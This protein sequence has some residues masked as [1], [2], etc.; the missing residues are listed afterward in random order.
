MG[1]VKLSKVWQLP[2]KVGLGLLILGV[3]GITPLASGHT[4]E[5]GHRSRAS[6][7]ARSGGQAPPVYQRPVIDRG[8]LLQATQQMLH[9]VSEL[10]GLPVIHSVKAALQSREEIQRSLIKDLDERTTADE[11]EA[12]TKL[13]IKLG[14]VPKDFKY[15]ELL[16]RIIEEQVA[17]YY[18]PRT[19]SLYLADWLTLDEQNSVMV[20]ELAHALQDQHFRLERFSR[21]PKGQSDYELAISSLI[22]GDATAVML[23]HLLKPQRLD[24]ASIPIPLS[25]IFDQ[26]QKSDDQ[27]IKVLNSAPA[28]VRESLLFPYAYGTTFVQYILIHSSWK[29]ISEA[30]ADP[31]DSTEQVLHPA[32]FLTRDYPVRIELPRLEKLLGKA[33]SRRI[34]DTTG[35]FGYYLILSQYVDKGKAR[36]AA[37]GWDGDQLALYENKRTGTLLLVQYTTWDS[38]ADADEFARAYAERTTACYTGAREVPSSGNTTMH[39][40]ET[41]EGDVYLERRGSDVLILEGLDDA[42]LKKLPHLVKALWGSRKTEKGPSSNRISTR[43]PH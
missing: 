15:R 11:F 37:E 12:S 24:I 43:L 38:E 25:T 6:R 39:R 35:E 20:H 23:N 7:L 13:L 32:K 31:P 4:S 21:L 40:W 22:E 2:R 36:R 26:L 28:V 17:G 14:L 16:T 29:R 19:K 5:L 1:L 42:A 8:E 41:A 10:R 33:T 3:V 9:Y 30:Y 18:R 34:F 27:R